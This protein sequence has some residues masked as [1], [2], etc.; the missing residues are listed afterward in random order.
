[1]RLTRTFLLTAALVSLLSG[2]MM[3]PIR[4]EVPLLAG[5][6]SLRSTNPDEVRLLLFNNSSKLMFGL[7]NT[8][9]INIRL[10][11]KGVGGPDIGEYLLLQIP[12]GKHQLELVHL[13]MVEF[14]SLHEI[15]AQDGPLIVEVRATPLSNEIQI[16]RTLPT[17]NHLPSPFTPYVPR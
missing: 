5:D 1:M 10:N 7:D 8:G 11:G 16:H 9:R 15:D 3:A 6:L 13:D 2:C 4:T 17:G 12:K 14:R